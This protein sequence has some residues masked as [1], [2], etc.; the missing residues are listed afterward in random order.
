ML[1]SQPD[2]TPWPMPQHI[3]Q[4]GQCPASSGRPGWFRA[5]DNARYPALG[6][7]RRV[8]DQ[9]GLMGAVFNAAKER[10]LDGFIA[11]QIGFLQMAQVVEAV[12]D[13][14][15]AQDGLQNAT[16][17]LDNVLNTDRLAR[18]RADET[19]AQAGR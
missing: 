7:A 1:K 3:P 18:I 19:I 9:G 10:A 4:T 17:T 16:M 5:P 12:M 11:G 13:K 14:M 2:Q 8:M 6:L 15:S